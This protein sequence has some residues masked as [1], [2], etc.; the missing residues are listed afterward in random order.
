[1]I[2]DRPLSVDE[3]TS[4]FR[5]EGAPAIN[6]S[7]QYLYIKVPTLWQAD[8]TNT[9]TV[10]I[11]GPGTSTNDTLVNAKANLALTETVLVPWSSYDADLYTITATLKTSGGVTIAT[12]YFY[13]DKKYDGAPTHLY[14]DEYNRFHLP[15]GAD[16]GSDPIFPFT[17]WIPAPFSR[18]ID[19]YEPV[20]DIG[21]NYNTAT[22]KTWEYQLN[23]YGDNTPSIPSIGRSIKVLGVNVTTADLAGFLPSAMT[24]TDDAYL[25]AYWLLDEPTLPNPDYPPEIVAGARYYYHQQ[26]GTRLTFI[27]HEGRQ[28]LLDKAIQPYMYRYSPLGY[29]GSINDSTGFDLYPID[30]AET[31]AQF[32][33]CF[34]WMDY[35]EPYIPCIPF[36]EI[37]TVD[38]PGLRRRMHRFGCCRG[39]R[40]SRGRRAFT[41]SSITMASMPTTR[42]HG[43]FTQRSR[44]WSLLF[45]PTRRPRRWRTTRQPSSRRFA[46]K[47]TARCGCLRP[48]CRTPA[49]RVR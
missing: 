21:L 45:L 1:M 49:I 29:L 15:Y 14:L 37:G 33:E 23:F 35:Y 4:A 32:V 27:N 19:L 31:V 36:V 2:W 18:D 41:G 5:I 26:D 6:R 34:D 44:R 13:Y 42:A 24:L 46:R 9:L 17:V 10:T 11:T 8:P 40:S 48:E 43:R 7:A 3:I 47:Q 28:A 38:T 12:D 39:F 20:T 22:G 16:D 25:Q 30:W